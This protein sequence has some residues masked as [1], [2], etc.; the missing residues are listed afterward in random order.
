MWRVG[1]SMMTRRAGLSCCGK[2]ERMSILSEVVVMLLSCRSK[3]AGY[4]AKDS[5]LCFWLHTSANVETWGGRRGLFGLFSPAS[6]CVL[7]GLP[8]RG[9]LVWGSSVTGR[10]P[11]PIFSYLISSSSDVVKVRTGGCRVGV[12]PS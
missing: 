2:E 5:V 3:M 1:S 8:V 7:T 9:S 12:V 6:V 11:A 4:E 10:R